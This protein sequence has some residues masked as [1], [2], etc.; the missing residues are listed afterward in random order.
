[1]LA[2]RCGRRRADDSHRQT[3]SRQQPG[4]VGESGRLGVVRSP[5]ERRKRGHRGEDRLD[6]CGIVGGSM[7]E[8]RR[9][10]PLGDR[11]GDR[12]EVAHPGEVQAGGCR[13]QDVGVGDELVRPSRHD[14]AFRAGD[15][16]DAA[17]GDEAVDA[18]GGLDRDVAA[19]GALRG[20][21]RDVG[22]RARAHRDHQPVVA[23]LGHGALDGL[24]VGANR[25]RAELDDR[26]VAEPFGEP[27]DDR[28]RR[29]A[30]RPA[31]AEDHRRAEATGAVVDRVVQHRG[32]DADVHAG[33]VGVAPL[34]ERREDRVRFGNAD[35]GA[36]ADSTA[37]K[38]A[39]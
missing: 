30:V 27:I 33:Q 12:G 3:A 28:T 2:A 20:D 6:D 38:A 21:L 14:G 24:L 10:L 39:R 15:D 37:S 32:T 25:A 29:R 9:E 13:G 36:S 11:V 4:Q 34:A 19:S 7:A 22:E 1:M 23:D 26:A 35:H 17:V 16:E 31:V 18:A 5:G 8:T